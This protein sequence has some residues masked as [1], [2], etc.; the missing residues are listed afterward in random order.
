MESANGG[1]GATGLV[2]A[3]AGTRPSSLRRRRRLWVE[4]GDLFRGSSADLK[5]PTAAAFIAHAPDAGLQVIAAEARPFWV[6]SRVAVH[7]STF[8]K[9]AGK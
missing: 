9:S 1:L 4:H 3:A 8:R 7:S 5:F 2:G 6:L